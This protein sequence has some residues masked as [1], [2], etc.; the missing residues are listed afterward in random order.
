MGESLTAPSLTD[1][2][3]SRRRDVLL[4]TSRELAEAIPLSYVI[5]A[6]E[7]AY[8]LSGRGE[9]AQHPR[10]PLHAPDT[11]TFL[12]LMPALSASA[13]A[14]AVHAYTGGNRG[15]DVP[16]KVTLL[17]RASDG[18]LRA[19][20]ESEWLSWA[21]TGATGA[22]AT[23]HLAT[24]G[25]NV[26][27]IIGSGR[28]ASAQFHAIAA[29]RSIARAYVFS[30]SPERRRHFADEMQSATGVP[31]EALG[32]A[33]EVV[34]A[35]DIVSTATTSTSPVFA[36]RALHPG[37]HINAIG[38]HYPNR[39]ELDGATMA[40]SR[41]FADDP[42]RSRLEDGELAL[43]VAERTTN[44]TAAPSAGPELI[45]LADVVAGRTEGRRSPDEVTILLSGGLASEYLLAATAVVDR[46]EEL[47]LGT[48]VSW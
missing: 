42:E 8:R 46:A 13:N 14:V 28:Q 31:T 15:A 25:A 9:L 27:G 24:A 44:G 12:H 7:R 33:D 6:V 36:A 26:L 39:R 30:R 32:S 3:A 11:K 41:V 37:L 20:V 16:Q 23:R 29:S 5:E 10:L 48:R 17:F 45:A 35:A 2:A 1:A 4:L 21:R 47:G 38:A 22:V 40:R 34:E 19:I 18:G 43:A